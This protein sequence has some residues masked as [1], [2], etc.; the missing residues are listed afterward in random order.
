MKKIII[1]TA[2]AAVFLSVQSCNSTD[3]DQDVADIKVTNGDADFSKYIALGN[4]LTSGYRDGALYID[5][6][7]ESYPNIIAQ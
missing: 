7:N 1:S 6:Q 3:F 2:I 5:A 4:S